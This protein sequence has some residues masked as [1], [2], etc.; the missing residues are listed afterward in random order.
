MAIPRRAADWLF[1]RKAAHVT[2][3]LVVAF[4]LIWVAG[5][6]GAGPG[7]PFDT[8]LP[9]TRGDNGAPAPSGSTIRLNHIQVVGTHNSYHVESSPQLMAMIRQYLPPLARAIEY[10]HLPLGKQFETERVRSVEIDVFADPRGGLYASPAGLALTTGDPSRKIPELLAPGFKVFHVQDI[11]VEATCRTFVACL[12][13]IKAWSD[14]HPAHVPIAILVEAKDDS[15][16]DPLAMG[17]VTPWKIGPA[18]F[19]ALDAEIRSVFAPANLITPD[20]VRGTHAT[21]EEAVLQDGWPTLNSVRGRVLFLMVDGGTKRDDYRAGHP[22][23]QGRVMFT[24]AQPGQPDAAFVKQDDAA[25]NFDTIKR[26]V[27]AGYIVR[28][29]A[30]SDTEEARSG[31]TTNRDA[32]LASGAQFVSTDYPVPDPRFGTNYSVALPGGGAARCNPVSAPPRCRDQDLEP[33]P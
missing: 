27:A 20:D 25:R 33:A 17:F 31:D 1:R 15:I 30:D 6:L 13:D 3:A 32:A 24:N 14:A 12:R 28:T 22:V 19:D 23:L 21:L 5:V 4:S 18:E 7:L 2:V 16:P 9:G 10:T 8:F 11:D 29:R 26:L